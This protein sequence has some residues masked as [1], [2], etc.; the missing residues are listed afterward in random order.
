MNVA[1]DLC[2]FLLPFGRLCLNV[3]MNPSNILCWNVRGLNSR[4]RQDSVRTLINSMKVDVVCLQETKMSQISHGSILTSLGSDFSYFVELPSVGASGGILVAWR[5]A[6]GPAT[7]TR[8]DNF[9]VSVQ[10]CPTNGQAWWL[11]C[12]YGPQGDD[13][14]VLFLQELREIRLAC[15]GPWLTLGD[16]NL[17]TSDAD[18]NNSNLNRAMMGRFRRFISDLSLKE[19]PLHG[20]KFTWSNQQDSP[21]L[22]KLDRVL[23]S[24]D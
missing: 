22:V 6:L 3:T 24:I 1:G 11:T 7:A 9:S 4:A 23:C 2:G 15:Q 5:H 21:T 16:Y 18:K 13:N 10:F 20:R 17:I 12:V 8:V 14:K 19:L